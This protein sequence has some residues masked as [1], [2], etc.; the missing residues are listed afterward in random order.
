MDLKVL[1]LVDQETVRTLER[2]FSERAHYPITLKSL[3][4]DWRSFAEEV[5]RGYEL[6]LEDYVND[7]TTRT[8]LEDVVTALSDNGR[9][10]LTVILKP[11]DARYTHATR[12]IN[13]SLYGVNDLKEQ[14]WLSRV[15]LRSDHE[16]LDNLAALGL[17]PRN[18]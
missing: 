1:N 6:G 18:E 4:E 17:T 13:K 5:E 3:V 16:L 7:L 8:L 2:Q 15:P 9:R 14:W 11:I 12:E 10:T